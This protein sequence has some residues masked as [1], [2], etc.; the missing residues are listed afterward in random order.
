MKTLGI[1]FGRWVYQ[2]G[3]EFDATRYYYGGRWTPF[4]FVKKWTVIGYYWP[5]VLVYK[6]EA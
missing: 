4:I 5:Q 1:S 3:S 2:Y 6:K